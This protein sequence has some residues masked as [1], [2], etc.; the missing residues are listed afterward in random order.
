ETSKNK[1]KSGGNMTKLHEL[2]DLGQAIW[3]DY[4]RRSFIRSGDLQKL[5]DQGVRGVTSNPAIFEKAI[6]HS[7]DYDEQMQELVVEG[8]SVDEIYE[9]LAVDDIKQ[10]TDLFR[11]VFDQTK[12]ADGFVS[13]EVSPGLANDTQGTLAEA[14]RYFAELRRPNLMI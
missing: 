7:D 8:K 13:L 10:A 12:G 14:R 2:A 6:G 11:P 4:I 9:A 5:I 3:L 1:I